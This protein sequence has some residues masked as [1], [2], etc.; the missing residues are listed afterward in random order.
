MA[1]HFARHQFTTIHP[2]EVQAQLLNAC[3]LRCTYCKC[4]EI[5]TRTLT[6]DQWLEIVRG[7]ARFGT[8][9]FKVQGGEPTLFKGMDEICAAAKAAGMRTAVTTNG[10]GIV[11]T[12]SLLDALDEVVVSVDALRPELHDRCRGAGS[13]AIAMQAAD[14][15]AARGCRVYI[16]MIVHKETACDLEP[17]LAYCESRGFLLNAQAVQF[18]THYQDD[19]AEFLALDQAAESALYQ[20]LADLKRQGRGL[21]FSAA[22]YERTSQWPDYRARTRAMEGHS[23]CM[24]GNFYVHI[25]PNGDV[26]P[27]NFHGGPFTAKN[28]VTDGLEAALRQARFHHCADCGVVHLEER[29]RLFTLKPGAILQLLRRG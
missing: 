21:M 16:N 24:A 8:R 27:C 2:L 12:P 18:S 26:H 10:F 17:L 22:T 23:A 19:G 15:A 29:K 7:L 28:A 4:P 1:W 11:R 20:R 3:N 25:E 6:V 9:R 13:H 5:A 14:L